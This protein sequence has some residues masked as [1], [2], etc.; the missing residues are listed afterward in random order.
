MLRVT[1]MQ[2]LSKVYICEIIRLHRQPMRLMLTVIDNLWLPPKL[3]ITLHILRQHTIVDKDHGGG[4]TQI[5]YGKASEPE[6]SRPVEKCNFYLPT[7][8]WHRRWG[9][10]HWCF[11]KIFCIIKLK[12][13]GYQSYNVVCVILRLAI[14]VQLWLVTDGQTDRQTRDDSKC[15]TSIA[16]FLSSFIVG[17]NTA[18][19]WTSGLR[20]HN[21][22]VL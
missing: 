9:W 6:T 4:C 8:I 17:R 7:C 3:L 15:R 13:L 18:Y 11:V 14:L 12:S 10:S 5:Y 1:H 21:G 16:F 20:Q 2:C 22:L 19:F